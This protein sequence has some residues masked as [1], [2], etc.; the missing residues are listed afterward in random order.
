M[1]RQAL[2]DFQTLISITASQILRK[3]NIAFNA[4]KPF[5]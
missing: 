1:D 5:I 3:T 4:K 2:K